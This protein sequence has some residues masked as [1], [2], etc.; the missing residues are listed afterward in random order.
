MKFNNSEN[1]RVRVCL[2]GNSKLSK[3][4]HSLV[5]EFQSIADIVIIDSIFNDA[6]LA[7]RR[8]VEHDAVDVFISAGAN[9]YYLKD[10]LPVPVVSLKVRQSDL[11]N[12]VLRARQVSPRILLM[13]HEHQATWT[14][15]LDYV[16]GVNVDHRTYAMAEEAKDI[17]HTIRKDGFGV[18]IGS[19]YV[20]D[21]AEQADIPY[22]MVYSRESCRYMIRRA[23]TVAG[24]YKRE[25]EQST[26]AQFMIDNAPRPTIITNRDEQVISFNEGVRDLIPDM[27]TGKRIDRFLDRRFLQSADTVAEGLLLGDRLCRVAKRAFE[28]GD[29]RVGNLYAIT[30]A[31]VRQHDRSAAGRQLVF[32]S[33]KMDEVTRLLQIYGATPG[34]VLL[35]GETGT[36]KELA[37]RQI[38]E[39]S[40]HSNGPFVAINCAAIPDE[41]FESELF[42]YA[43]GAFTNSKSG[44]Q[45]GLLESANRGTFFMDEINSL[46][47]PQQAKLLRVLQEREVRPV[48]ARKSIALDIKFVAACNHNLLE[49]VKAGR[50]REDLYYRLNVF[51]INLPPLRERPEDIEPLTR[52]FIDRLGQQ[53]S[54]DADSE[55]LIG[56]LMPLF[57]RFDWPGNVRQLENLLERLLVSTTLY[58]SIDEFSRHL[59]SLAPELFTRDLALPVGPDSG[60]L[61]VVEQEEILKVLDRFGGNKTQAAEYLG[62]SQTTLWRRLKQIRAATER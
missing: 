34:A 48:G 28:V 50:F 52:H 59:E 46:P 18:I 8:L 43:D 36:G 47:M 55:A 13:T 61:Q 26:F 15:F 33:E 9:A 40:T 11:V 6:L 58:P 16:E 42:G 5:P 1:K 3:M 21:L 44:G 4:V 7:A 54:I 12:A 27:A 24:E 37:A 29:E 20:C 10:T 22:V 49:E 2:I 57:N 30:A 62:I 39:S 35:R 14:E 41:L 45:S 25:R 56:V 60:H 51:I 53:Y 31:P 32:R 19:S 38:H 23:I 17:F